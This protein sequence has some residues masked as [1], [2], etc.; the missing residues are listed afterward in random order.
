M[1]RYPSLPLY[2]DSSFLSTEVE[3]L[4]EFQHLQRAAAASSTARLLRGS[5]LSKVKGEKQCCLYARSVRN[6]L[7]RRLFRDA[8]LVFLLK[9]LN[10][11]VRPTPRKD[12]ETLGYLK[13]ILVGKLF[14]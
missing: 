10:M 12:I 11:P 2:L 13:V 8:F 6:C 5:G 9:P 3:R 7:C 4:N 14:V 1:T